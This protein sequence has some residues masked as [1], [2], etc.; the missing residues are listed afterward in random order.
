MRSERR[1][2]ARGVL[3]RRAS[4]L[5]ARL[6]VLALGLALAGCGALGKDDE[7]PTPFG[8][9]TG[10]PPV[11]SAGAVPLSITDLDGA[12]VGT[13]SYDPGYF[14]LM[15]VPPPTCIIEEAIHRKCWTNFCAMSA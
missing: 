10:V 2:H 1:P 4:P 7:T 12:T 9:G 13:L 5:T 3:R 14:T 15:P 11:D 6:A 8:P